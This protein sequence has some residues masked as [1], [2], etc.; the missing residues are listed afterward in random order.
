MATKM[1]LEGGAPITRLLH[2]PEDYEAAQ[3]E[4]D[5]LVTPIP[6]AEGTAAYDRLE[7]LATLVRL[8]EEEHLEQVEDAGTPQEIVAFMLEQK[9]LTRAELAPIMGGRGRVSDFFTGFRP[10]LSTNQILALRDFLGISADL[11]IGSRKA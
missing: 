8:Y 4:I 9:G 11:L 7:V 6:P 3:Q 1:Y 10:N 2:S 5:R